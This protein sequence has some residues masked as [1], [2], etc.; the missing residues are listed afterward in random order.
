MVLQLDHN[1]G[2]ARQNSAT[3]A[4]TRY[5]SRFEDFNDKRARTNILK[6]KVSLG[7]GMRYLG[8][9]GVRLRSV[10]P[11]LEEE[12]WLAVDTQRLAGDLVV[13]RS[14][15]FARRVG[16]RRGRM[17]RASE[18]L[19]ARRTDGQRDPQNQNPF[20][21]YFHKLFAVV[22]HKRLRDLLAG[23]MCPAS[24]GI[25]P[26]NP[27]KFSSVGPQGRSP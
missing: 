8:E 10:N 6:D 26:I 11:D 20:L 3:A 21:D 5:R 23:R 12:C 13:G 19:V 17:F 4:W 9:W 1:I 16:I 18:L 14:D 25:N 2:V 27:Q 15:D 22:V 24:S 7:I